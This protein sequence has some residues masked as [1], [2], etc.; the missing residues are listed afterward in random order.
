MLARSSCNRSRGGR[1]AALFHLLNLYC[2]IQLTSK[3][4]SSRPTEVAYAEL[5]S[6][7]DFYNAHL[8][9]GMLPSCILTFQR[10]KRT[11]GYFSFQRFRNPGTGASSDEIAL[12][13][14]YFPLYPML[15]V[16]QTLVHEMVHQWQYHHGKP[17][18][19]CYH[20][21]QWADKMESIGLM[22]SDTGQ[23]G[24]KRTGQKVADYAIPGGRFEQATSLLLAE[25]FKISWLDRYPIAPPR[26]A[27]VATAAPAR[28][29]AEDDED[30]GESASQVFLETPSIRTFEAASTTSLAQLHPGLDLVERPISTNRSNR[31]KYTCPGCSVSVWGKPKLRIKCADCEELMLVDEQVESEV[32]TRMTLA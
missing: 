30:D 21:R 23:P 2:T 9:E 14:E 17:S 25:G 24:G 18:R 29:I 22:P 5:Q 7:Y 19:T 11:M 16:L 15:E 10:E 28:L 6:A 12:N 13:P 20:D 31:D 1:L 32:A 26:A 3:P 4:T 27:G 8:F